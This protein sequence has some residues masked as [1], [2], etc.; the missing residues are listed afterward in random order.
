M[1]DTILL[2][3]NGALSSSLQKFLKKERVFIFDKDNIDRLIH[4]KGDLLIDCSLPDAFDSIYVY[5][6]KNRIPAIICSTNHSK[7]QVFQMKELSKSLPLFKSENLS[8]GIALIDKILR[9]NKNIVKNYDLFLFDFHH[10]SKKDSP[11][12]T[13]KKIAEI[14]DHQVNVASVRSKNI[15]GE[16]QLRLFDEDEEITITHKAT[17]KDLFA[18]GILKAMEFIDGKEPGFYDMEDLIDEI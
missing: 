9:E 11:S 3:G 10:R 4:T 1:F 16:H 17:S 6:K 15:I 12:G 14:L 2:I 18:K 8:L 13:G 7:E 5:L